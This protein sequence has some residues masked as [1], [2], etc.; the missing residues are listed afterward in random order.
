MS[1]TELLSP[2]LFASHL[3]LKS[4]SHDK[5]QSNLS[6]ESLRS[7]LLAK[8]YAHKSATQ[9]ALHKDFMPGNKKSARGYKRSYIFLST[10]CHVS[11]VMSL[12]VP[13]VDNYS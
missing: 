4:G 7:K 12:F 10:L 11:A 9:P 3:V 1:Q 2:V 6:A 5:R 13:P 8:S